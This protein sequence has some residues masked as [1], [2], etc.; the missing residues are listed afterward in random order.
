MKYTSINFELGKF[1]SKLLNSSK[2][3]FNLLEEKAKR[4]HK[5]NIKLG[6]ILMFPSLLLFISSIR[7]SLIFFIQ[8]LKI[9]S[10]IFLLIFQFLISKKSS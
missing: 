7:T 2:I 4:L 9:S 6:Y 8:I 10:L 3:L 5:N 1:F